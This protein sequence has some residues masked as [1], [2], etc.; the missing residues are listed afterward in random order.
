MNIRILFIIALLGIAAGI[1]S[2]I[3]Y[4][5]YSQPLPPLAL[6][7]NPYPNAVYAIGV[8]ESNQP[9]GSNIEIFPSVAGTIT[10]IAV[11]SGQKVSKDTPLF[12]IDDSIQQALVA[13][14]LANVQLQRANLK[15]VTDQLQ[16]L[17]KSYQVNPRSVSKINL[18]DAKNAVK[19]ATETLNGALKQY[20]ADNA[21]LAKYTITAPTDGTVIRI[22]AAPGNYASPQGTFDLYTRQQTPPIIMV[23]SSPQLIVRCYVNE[24]LVPRLPI[25]A[26]LT[27]TLFVRGGNQPGI[28]L[29]YLNIQPFTQPALQLSALLSPRNDFRA[30]PIQFTFQPPKSQT[31]YPGQFVDIY[32][33][34]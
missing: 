9:T 20:A 6:N 10:S 4:K 33:Q 8:V 18:D 19:A 11:T 22:A 21:Q 5:D 29:T 16:K 14:D 30:L 12:K 26:P 15:N 1:I 17:A 25:N 13:T 24:L 27:A 34:T 31:I 28:P 23:A 3:V 32:I 2:A 7:Y